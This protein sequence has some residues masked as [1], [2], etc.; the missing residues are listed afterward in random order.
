MFEHRSMPLLP[1]RAF[2]RR[3]A[4]HALFALAFVAGSLAIGVAGYHWIEGMP[5][6]DSLLNASMLLGGMGPVGD[7]HTVAGKLFASAYALFAGIG[8]LVVAGVLF[9]PVIHRFLHK[10]HLE[11]AADQDAPRKDLPG[12]QSYRADRSRLPRPAAAGGVAADR[13]RREEAPRRG[14]PPRREYRPEE[15]G[16]SQGEL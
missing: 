13:S 2:V 5:F 8:F 11:L 9:A 16:D 1:R 12:R 10:F 6:I 14:E 4:G 7:L 3:M 15:D